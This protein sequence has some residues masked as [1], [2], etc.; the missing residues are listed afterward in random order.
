MCVHVGAF[1]CMHVHPTKIQANPQTIGWEG[2]LLPLASDP[3][4]HQEIRM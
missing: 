3:P 1:V 2:P 4:S